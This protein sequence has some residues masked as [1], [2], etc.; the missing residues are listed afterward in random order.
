[1][2]RIVLCLLMG[3]AFGCLDEISLS[4]PENNSDAI[5]IRGR[6]VQGNPSHVIIDITTL[7]DFSL[8]NVP[9]PVLN[10]EV[11]LAD[12]LGNE[13]SL[14]AKVPGRYE[15]S[16]NNQ[17]AKVLIQTGRRYKIIAQIPEKGTYESNWEELLPVPE[18][19]FLS[20]ETEE[21]TELNALG[22][23]EQN[24][25][26]NFLISTSFNRSEPPDKR[27][28]KWEFQGVYRF[29]ES[30]QPGA[31]IPTA[32]TC[33]IFQGLNLENIVVFDGSDARGGELENYE[34]FAEPIDFRFSRGFY[35][36]V[37]QQS[38]SEAAFKYWDEI[39]VLGDFSGNLFAAPPGKILGNFQNVENEAEEVFGFFYV[40]QQ[41]TSRIYIDPDMVDNPAVY[42]PV[43]G[44]PDTE[45]ICYDCLQWSGNSSL[46]KPD[47]WTD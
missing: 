31:V 9:D 32:K 28:F 21:R 24:S 33:Y 42:C 12:E 44:M 38:L 29:I 7:S 39:S 17:E 46:Q 18:I 1:M 10:A 19:T 5:V 25:Y 40:T 37:Y 47:F 2:R 41:D 34:L 11:V 15:V 20:F 16:I 43:E 8:A 27:F 14:F 6:L 26:I 30:N 13:Q 22:N 23:I 45:A 36:T 35:L 4:V 3:L